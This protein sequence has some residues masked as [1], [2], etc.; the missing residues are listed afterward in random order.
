VG[1]VSRAWFTSY[2]CGCTLYDLDHAHPPYCPGCAPGLAVDDSTASLAARTEA[3]TTP[4]PVEI[5]PGVPFGLEP[6]GGAA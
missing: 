5:V 3:L 1:A 2:R 4:E 6:L